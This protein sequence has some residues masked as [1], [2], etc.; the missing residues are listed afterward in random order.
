M[1]EAKSK[2]DIVNNLAEDEGNSSNG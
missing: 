2:A 1:M